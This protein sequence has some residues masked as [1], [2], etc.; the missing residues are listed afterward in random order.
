[1]KLHDLPR[2]HELLKSAT[3]CSTKLES[4]LFSLFIIFLLLVSFDA[5]N[6]TLRRI[7][8]C[9]EINLCLESIYDNTVTGEER[10]LSLGNDC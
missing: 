10:A 6:L 7:N 9:S 4:S 8:S 1:M 2:K 3:T 5:F